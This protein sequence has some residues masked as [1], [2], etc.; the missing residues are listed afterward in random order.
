M[1]LRGINTLRAI[2]RSESPFKK[3]LITTSRKSY[4]YSFFLLGAIIK[5]VLLVTN[6]AV[7]NASNQ[8]T[9]HR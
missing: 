3:C 1:Q 5:S 2:S 6:L 8:Y 7:L 4:D 9:V